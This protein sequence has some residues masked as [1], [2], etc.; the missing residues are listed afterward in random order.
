MLRAT[1]V[2]VIIG[3][4]WGCATLYTRNFEIT[5]RNLYNAKQLCDTNGGLK[6]VKVKVY[7]RSIVCHNGSTFNRDK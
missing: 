3:L 6:L 7:K 5:G 1:L 4:L 2:L